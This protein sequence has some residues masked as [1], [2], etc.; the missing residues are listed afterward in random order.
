MVSPGNLKSSIPA[1]NIAII[2]PTT[3]EKQKIKIIL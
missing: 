1:T 2:L 3:R